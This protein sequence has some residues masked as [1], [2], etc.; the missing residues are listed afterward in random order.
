MINKSLI[1]CIIQYSYFIVSA[2]FPF[3]AR[4]QEQIS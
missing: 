1:K 4:V 3:L 2:I